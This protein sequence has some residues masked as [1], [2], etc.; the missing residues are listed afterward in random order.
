M[1]ILEMKGLQL[2]FSLRNKKKRSEV[3]TKK[4]DFLINIGVNVHEV[5]IKK[6]RGKI[7]EKMVL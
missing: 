1:S 6:A 5:E 2:S 7:S 3:N 4:K